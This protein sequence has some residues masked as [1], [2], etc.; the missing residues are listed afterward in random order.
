M[1]RNTRIFSDL[2][3]NFTAH[4]ITGDIAIKYDENAI[5]T[6]VKNLVLTQNYER[7]F[8]SEIGSP[9][10][11]MLFELPSPLLFIS[12]Q[13]VITDLINNFEPRVS[14]LDVSVNQQSDDNN[15]LVVTI[16]FTILNTIRPITLDVV[17][18]RTR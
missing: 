6:S 5:K 15:S 10:Y 7:P 17:L 1:S 8:H 11:G 3:L 9:L 18:E 12:I 2:D 14:L 4:P 16:T 13:R